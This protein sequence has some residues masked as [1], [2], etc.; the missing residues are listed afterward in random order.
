MIYKGELIIDELSGDYSSP[1]CKLGRMVENGEIIRVR[2][3]LY[4]PDP[5]TEPYVLAHLVCEPSYI[6]FDCALAYYDIIPERVVEITCA[7][8]GKRKNKVFDTPFGRYS[9]S[10]I[11]KSAFDIGVDHGTI[12]G[13][14]F[15]IATKEK[16]VCDKLYKMPPATSLKSFKEMMFEFLRMDE[17]EIF[18]LNRET[19]ESYC[20]VY[21]CTNVR[22]LHRLLEIGHA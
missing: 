13:R 10:D 4:E 21:R 11:P 20:E 5:D 3:G 18:N 14:D 7:T 2:R 17:D 22:N 12:D 15:F 1:A 19:V 8:F 16:A 9:Y 6:S